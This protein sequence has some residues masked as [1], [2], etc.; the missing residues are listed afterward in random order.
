M[1][2]NNFSA[3]IMHPFTT[4]L[5]EQE[6][7][8]KRLEDLMTD[9]DTIDIQ[10]LK[11][12]LVG[13][14]GV[15]K[16]TTLNRLL[17]TIQNISTS[18]EECQ[19]TLLADCIQVIAFLSE[20]ATE[21]LSSRDANEETKMVFGLVHGI[22]ALK[23]ES[24]KL[25]TQDKP[26]QKEEPASS[27]AKEQPL[28]LPKAEEPQIQSKQSSK[29]P[30]KPVQPQ[31][32]PTKTERRAI[33]H[34]QSRLIPI[35]ARLQK[36]IKTG[37]Y[38]KMA[39]LLGN[40]L[41]NINDIGGQPGFLEMLPALSTGPAMYLVFL[42]LS[43]ELNK[44][45]EIPF[46]RDATIITPFKAIH[47]VEATISQILSA[48]ASVHSL[49]QDLSS[50]KKAAEFS[51]KFDK[52]QQVSPVAT[53][54]GTH[55]DKLTNPEE[56]MKAIDECLKKVTQKF[57]KILAFPTNASLFSVDNY[58][59]TEQSD[60]GPIREFMNNI[61]R[62][63][64][65]DASLPI[66][67]KWLIFGTV[68]RREYKIVKMEDCLEIG[69]ILKMDVGEIDFCLWYLDCIGSL[70]HYTNIAD[71]EDNWFKNHVICSPQVIFDS[72]SQLIV[73]SLCTIHLEGY[74]IEEERKEL[75][76]MGQFSIDSIEK[77]CFCEEIMKKLQREELIPAKQLVKLLNHVNLLSPIIH[78]KKDGS[79]RIT[80]LMPAVLECATQD[81]LSTPTSPDDNNPEPLFIAFS[82]G[83]VPTGTFCGLITRLVSL[84]PTKIFGL[85]WKLVEEGV[86]RNCISF[87]IATSNIVTLIAHERCYEIRVTRKTPQI[88]LHELCSYV[89][90]VILYTLKS[91][92]NQLVPQIAFQCPC[93]EHESNRD[94][95]NL[96]TLSDDFWVQFVCG[97][98]PVTLR[99][100]QQVWLGKVSTEADY[101]NSQ[102]VRSFVSGVTH[103]SWSHNQHNCYVYRLRRLEVLLS[104][105]CSNSLRK[106]FL[107]TGPSPGP[108]VRSRRLVNP[109]FSPSRVSMRRTLVTTD[110]R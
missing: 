52:F 57:E 77:Y 24:S 54:I 93:S 107:S 1:S 17:K 75:I 23:Q 12:F 98:N 39:N 83:Y 62:T 65:K 87:Y 48:I 92:Y 35:K 53:L 106:N 109:M 91:L 110:V 58:A 11:V 108:D 45:Y 104:W 86:K 21:W 61:F 78:T 46:S 29:L 96:C 74:V 99:K 14:P 13:P 103:C 28:E 82:C 66:R 3:D 85:T 79:E 27:I 16:T 76:K 36:L 97:S 31:P 40:T 95:N 9:K 32:E 18:A 94:I 70:M 7:Y 2:S 71:D 51:K 15:G 38:S 67:P 69:K 64:F 80:Y 43:K 5:E 105:K 88:T 63:H 42:D 25:K 47:T 102:L 60:I 37:D 30:R 101:S 6:Q 41:L 44:P 100:D 49:S 81:E 22:G 72:T 33:A 59:G 55:K 20:N 50:Y 89:L 8:L 19:S 84:G 26:K 10:C 90:S 68:L 4:V 34:Q 73:A 56:E